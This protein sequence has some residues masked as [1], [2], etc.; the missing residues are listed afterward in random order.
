[1]LQFQSSER[2]VFSAN[3]EGYLCAKSQSDIVKQRY[4]LTNI[5]KSYLVLKKDTLQSRAVTGR[6]EVVLSNSCHYMLPSRKMN[7]IKGLIT[8]E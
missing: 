3:D 8:A 5:R 1:M 4:T 2:F 7:S 6:I